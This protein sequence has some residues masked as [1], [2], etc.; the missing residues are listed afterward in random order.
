MGSIKSGAN[1]EKQQKYELCNYNKKCWKENQNFFVLFFSSFRFSF[2]FFFLLLF[3]SFTPYLICKLSFNI[4][5]L[6]KNYLAY[7]QVFTTSHKIPPSFSSRPWS[8]LLTGKS[9]P[10]GVSNCESPTRLNLSSMLKHLANFSNLTA[11]N[12]I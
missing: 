12:L 7:I 2:S 6:F 5:T 9:N 1:T 3:Q 4:Y 10:L 11:M 8:R